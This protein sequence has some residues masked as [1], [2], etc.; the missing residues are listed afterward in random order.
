MD[1]P[2]EG[3]R[4]L[5]WTVF[6]QGPT[7]TALLA[8]M[9]ADVI[10]IEEP[11][12]EP[13]RGITK[14]YGIE[15][16]LNF[17]Y[18]NQNRGK[19]GIVLDLTKEKARE[20]LCELV[21]NSD[22]FV[23]NLRY[24]FAKKLGLDYEALSKHNP[25]LIYALSSG[26]GSEGPDADLPSADFAGQARGGIWSVS[27]SEELTP[28]PLGAG[29]ADEIG[30]VMT[31]YG[32][33]MALFA[34]ERTGEGQMVEASLLGGQIE[35]GRLSLQQ[36]LLMG[37]L[38]APS[39]IKMLNSPMWNIYR[40]KDSKWVCLSVL[41]AD[42]FWPQFCKVMGKEEWATDPK[43]EN[44]LVRGQNIAELLPQVK[45]IFITKTR[46]EWVK[47][48]SEVD[49]AAAPVNDYADIANDPQVQANG[50]IMEIDDPIHGKVRVP[51]IPVKLS[52]TPGK[53]T[54]LAPE[55]GQHT[56]EVLQEVLG[57]SWEQLSELRDAEVY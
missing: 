42:R 54:K 53:V 34:R 38:P 56:E 33:M 20:V 26:Y 49:I 27:M 21:K 47:V 41:Q 15:V 22:V 31:A 2:L 55:L 29:F 25:K 14:M 50:Y 4:V 23:T 32:I 12:G 37:F 16:P 17:Y 18:Q 30:G 6:Q 40:C 35:V 57:Y 43:F 11:R 28:V 44:A 24:R 1:R 36:Y 51:G 3:I 13:A 9:G 39:T 48:F 5:D 45:E 10:K 8:D 19:R 52:K 7:A 46:E